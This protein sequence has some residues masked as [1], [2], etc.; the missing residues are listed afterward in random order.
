MK[1]KVLLPVLLVCL[2]LSANAQL[3]WEK[4]SKES[5]SHRADSINNNKPYNDKDYFY[6][7]VDQPSPRT[8]AVYWSDNKGHFWLFGGIGWD[9]NF[10]WGT[11]NDL[12]QFDVATQ[13]WSLLSDER[14][15][16]NQG[17]ASKTGGDIP[18]PRKNAISWVDPNGDIWMFGGQTF[19][20]FQYLDDVWVYH[21]S[22][23]SWAKVHGEGKINTTTNYG[24]KSKFNTLNQPG[25]RQGSSYWADGSGNLWLMG[26]TAHN[27]S[28]DNLVE[29]Y[30]DLWQF[31]I[32]KL[33]WAWIGGQ[34][35][36]NA[37]S[38]KENETPAP[39]PRKG[40]TTWFDQAAG[41][42]YLYGGY[43]LDSQGAMT[44][45]LSDLWTLSLKDNAWKMLSKSDTL[46]LEAQTFTYSSKDNT[47]GFRIDATGWMDTKSQ[48][49]YALGG[50]K[51]IGIDT[52]STDPRLWCYELAEGFWHTEPMQGAPLQLGSI[53]AFKTEKDEILLMLDEE[54]YE[55]QFHFRPANSIWKL[56][57]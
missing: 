17:V 10:K 36:A 54:F 16:S 15:I 1:G 31:D 45:G 18:Q 22:R 57:R 56:S 35:K 6:G 28:S 37:V 25:S 21:A 47:P 11:F 7:S 29:F 13:K 33:Q 24:E 46:N 41:Q 55:E 38:S 26:G 5:V 53:S 23:K 32:Q 42:L 40:S 34:Q 3:K 12:W 52:V 44:G 4:L 39:S 19:L 8:D 51:R 9:E 30:S 2:N 50:Q 49:L 48:K 27:E 20:D 43:G 14:N